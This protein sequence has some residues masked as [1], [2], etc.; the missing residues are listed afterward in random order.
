MLSLFGLLRYYQIISQRE[1]EVA[2]SL[3]LEAQVDHLLQL[4]ARQLFLAPTSREIYSAGPRQLRRQLIRDR[5]PAGSQLLETTAKGEPKMIA[6]GPTPGSNRELPNTV[7]VDGHEYHFY[8]QT[9]ENSYVESDRLTDYYQERVR[10]QAY[11]AGRESYSIATLWSSPDLLRPILTQ[12]VQTYW[13]NHGQQPIN[14]S[15]TEFKSLIMESLYQKRL[16]VSQ[17][18]ISWVL[19]I[20]TIFGA[21]YP[22][23]R[24]LKKMLDPF[25]GWGDRLIGALI[26]GKSYQGYDPNLALQAGYHQMIQDLSYEDQAVKVTPMAFEDVPTKASQ[27][28]EAHLSMYDFMLTSPPYFDIEV[29]SDSPT[30][31]IARYPDFDNWLDQFYRPCLKKA[32][33]RIKPGGFGIIQINDRKDVK[34]VRHTIDIMNAFGYCGQFAAVSPHGFVNIHLVARIPL[35]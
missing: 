21:F 32:L 9:L 33:S 11:N 7:K 34:L 6:Y 8:L 17:Y 31:S 4:V 29:Y 1:E 18:R 35:P 19:W 16:H 25:S 5:Q 15:N 20:L 22:P 12:A 23:E 30:Q 13:D 10:H 14:P 24:P 3:E 26:L 2:D 28:G 27:L